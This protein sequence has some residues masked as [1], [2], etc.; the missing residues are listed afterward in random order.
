MNSLRTKKMMLYLWCG[1]GEIFVLCEKHEELAK[2]LFVES[3]EV[4]K[5]DR[6]CDICR[7]V[8]KWGLI[9]GIPI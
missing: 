1:R 6:S 9:G 8:D 4:C 5:G 2:V 3:V 7:F